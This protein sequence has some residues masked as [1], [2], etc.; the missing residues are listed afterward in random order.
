[1]QS[2]RGLLLLLLTFFTGGFCSCRQEKAAVMPVSAFIIEL[3]GN[4]GMVFTEKTTLFSMTYSD[5]EFILPAALNQKVSGHTSDRL[6]S[7]VKLRTGPGVTLKKGNPA[8]FLGP[9][10]YLDIENPMIKEKA[11]RFRKSTDP[12]RDIS[13]FVYGHI[14]DK[15]TGIPMISASVI[16]ENRS[17][18]CTEHSI[19]TTALLRAAGIPARCVVGVILAEEFAGRQNVF[20][21]HMWVEAYYGGKWVFA[22]STRPDDIHLNRYIAFAYHSLETEVPLDYMAAL[23]SLTDMTITRIP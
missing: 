23:T 10:P 22:D 8:K 6:T 1:M 12:V 13:R 15:K 16:L 3:K 19:L 21:Y 17:G 7:T 4:S 2:G 5:P 11:A 9:T 20:V 14:T 18:D